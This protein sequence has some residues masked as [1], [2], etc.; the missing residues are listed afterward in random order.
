MTFKDTVTGPVKH[1]TTLQKY[2]GEIDPDNPGV[3]P[4]EIVTVSAWF[5]PDGTEI[6][7]PERIAELEGN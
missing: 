2:H 3:E 4:F 7:D 6:T 1:T 5:E